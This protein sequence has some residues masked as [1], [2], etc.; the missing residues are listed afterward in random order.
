VKQHKFTNRAR[1]AVPLR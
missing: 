1:H